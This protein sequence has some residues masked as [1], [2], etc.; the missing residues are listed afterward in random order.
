MEE[1]GKVIFIDNE[2]TF[3]E[4]VRQQLEIIGNKKGRK[5]IAAARAAAAQYCFVAVRFFLAAIRQPRLCYVM[6]K[7]QL[8]LPAAA[9]MVGA[10]LRGAAA[11]STIS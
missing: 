4:V 1:S 7:F 2:D 10:S 6:L 11:G 8:F 3:A 9:G 5:S